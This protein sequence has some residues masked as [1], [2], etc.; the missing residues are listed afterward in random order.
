MH[1]LIGRK[2]IQQLADNAKF[3]RQGMKKLGFIIYGTVL[4]IS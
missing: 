4:V 2:R 3:F 1:V